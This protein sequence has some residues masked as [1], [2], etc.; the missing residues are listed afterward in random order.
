MNN[1]SGQGRVEDIHPHQMGKEEGLRSGCVATLR[2][3]AI[4]F[5]GYI[6]GSFPLNF[7]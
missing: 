1:Q 5:V 6:W 2:G 7:I 4:I 3:E